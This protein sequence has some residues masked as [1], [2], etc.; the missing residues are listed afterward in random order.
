M[1]KHILLVM[2]LFGVLT[3]GSCNDDEPVVSPIPG[4]DEEVV[5][6]A[7][8]PI[9]PVLV[10]T[11]Y[12]DFGSV[13]GGTRGSQTESP[14]ENGHY[15]NNIYNNDGIY[16]AVNSVF[17]DFVNSEGTSVGYKLTLNT[18]F[19]TNGGSGGGG[20]LTPDA[21]L[22]KDF[23]VS[24]ATEDYF[25]I[26]S[27]ENGN[28]FTIS[29]LD[30]EKAYKFYAFGSRSATEKRVAYYTMSGLNSYQGELQIAGTNLGGE[31]V[32]QNIANICESGLVYPD[33]EGTL[34]FA[35]SRSTGAYMAINAL[36]LEEYTDVK[37]PQT[38]T[39]LTITGSAV[40]EGEVPM[41]MISPTDKVSNKFEA[42]LSLQSGKFSFKGVTSEGVS[43]DIGKGHEPGVVAMNSYG[44]SAEVTGPVYIVVD[45]S[46]KS[47]TI[48]PV[49]EWSIVGSVTE[50]GWNAGTGVPLAYQGKGVWGGRV[51]LTGLGTASDR[52]RFNF[53]MNKSW[54]YTMKRISDT[55]NEV[56]FSN[57]GY[58]T[59]D[60]NLNHGTYNI[61][62]DLRR[63]AF[64]IDCGE[65]GIDPFK[66]SV[67]GSSVANGQGADSNHGYAYMFGELQDERFKNQETRLPWYTSG[68]SIGGNSTL[69]LLARYNDLLY[70]CG[71]YV[72][73]GLSLGNEGI[74]GAADQQA[75][76]NQFKD[77]MQTLI[78]KAREDGK[79]PV[80]M[81]NYTRGDFEESD[82][83]Y[84][85]QMNL[86]IHE[87][88]LPSVNM[89]G[90]ID[91]GSG[92]WADGYQNGTD[93]YHPNTEGHREF[94]Y[95]MVPSLFDAIEAGKTLPARVSGTSYTLAGKVLE[96]TPEETVHPFTISFKVKGATDGTIA[97]FTNGGNTMGTLKIQE[98]KV[99]Y[100]SPSQ[101][102]IVG[103]NVTDN[104]WHVVSLTHYYA[105]GRTLLYTDKS[106]AGEL[107]EK[108]T[109]G[110]FIIGD[111][112]STEGR[113][114][115]ELF[116]Y[117]SAM[118]E[119]EIN[120]LCDGSMLKSSL[121]IYAPLDGSKST[122][123]N[124]A[125]S[126][127]TVVVKSE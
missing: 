12:F 17:E 42:F 105:Q 64:Y 118:N 89:L 102:K 87:W 107:N 9:N 24:T 100:N 28:N 11:L 19:S 101:G 106:L 120:K 66:I 16:A 56:A 34:T 55:S 39:S 47:Y 1:K 18:R 33:E 71:K 37:R 79:Y 45:M 70:D 111:N 80:M 52:A 32:N 95:A 114:Y 119:E 72:I 82:Y 98:G 13:G 77:N 115:S 108:L 22:L 46:K 74:H 26:E 3:V 4:E 29:G 73:F 25:Y 36:K 123:E 116:F 43:T 126:M 5:I 61:T 103:G 75:I 76:Y 125:Q 113:E 65:E 35:V 38:F 48:T 67:M 60:I 15:W 20:L 83:R 68:I 27:G 96:F 117:R 86:L 58:S 30:K 7:P 57:S 8:E 85:K 40:E 53:I 6:P 62:L 23:A 59:S 51:K 63:F 41:H 127:N 84:V 122:I 90:A 69:N 121:E 2:A 21:E 14:D 104:Q 94:L 44:I 54:D 91:N 124:L 92:K 10:Q 49:E 88:D 81:N 78:S 112:S 50:G 31:G 93:L 110:K 99:V 97:T 109:V